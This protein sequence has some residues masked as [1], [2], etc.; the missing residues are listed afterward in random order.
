MTKL[1]QAIALC[2]N[3][4]FAVR[5]VGVTPPAPFIIVDDTAAYRFNTVEAFQDAFY[6][7]QFNG[8]RTVFT[9]HDGNEIPF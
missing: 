9:I 1:S 8:A 5:Y 7:C 3:N 4:E 6:D 2:V